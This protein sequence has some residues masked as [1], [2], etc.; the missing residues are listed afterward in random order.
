MTVDAVPSEVGPARH[1][2]EMVIMQAILRNC[3]ALGLAP[4]APEE[5]KRLAIRSIMNLR[6]AQSIR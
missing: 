2:G 6:R 5:A 4:L 1:D 3:A